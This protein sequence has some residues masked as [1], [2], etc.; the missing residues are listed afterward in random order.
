MEKLKW[1]RHMNNLIE[2]YGGLD[3]CLYIISKSKLPIQKN[4]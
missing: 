3:N 4:I 2:K 1:I